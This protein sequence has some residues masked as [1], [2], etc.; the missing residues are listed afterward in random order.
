MGAYCKPFRQTHL[1]GSPDGQLVIVDLPSTE[2]A[3]SNSYMLRLPNELLHNICELRFGLDPFSYA[4]L[5]ERRYRALK[6]IMLTCRRL[7]WISQC[8]LY[9]KLQFLLLPPKR[10][11]ILFHRSLME[12]QTIGKYCKSLEIMFAP[13]SCNRSTYFHDAIINQMIVDNIVKF[14]PAVRKLTI[15]NIPTW[16]LTSRPFSNIGQYMPRVEHLDIPFTNEY[17]LGI[18]LHHFNLP[19]LRTVTLSDCGSVDDGRHFTLIDQVRVI[20][21]RTL[22]KNLCLYCLYPLQNTLLKPSQDIIRTSPVTHFA[23]HFNDIHPEILA[24][25]LQWPRVPEE[26]SL[27]G[28]EDEGFTLQLLFQMLSPQTLHLLR[29]HL[30]RLTQA[31]NSA[32][33]FDSSIF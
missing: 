32:Q 21:R 2:V 4:H 22:L 29:I 3:S 7:Y 11:T 16:L 1:G 18:M 13:L 31:Q 24:A 12:S 30:D 15:N 28:Y 20:A 9:R 17:P 19:T 5:N 6:A 27:R 26:F 8:L 14:L 23:A 25:F 33:S 10:N